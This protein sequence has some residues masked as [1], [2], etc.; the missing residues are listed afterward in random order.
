MKVRYS[1]HFAS[2]NTGEG[3]PWRPGVAARLPWLS[4]G[5]LLVSILGG[6]A[7]VG[8]LVASNGQPISKWKYQ[9]T[10]Y[11]SIAY[12]ITNIALQFAFTEGVTTAWWRKAL[13]PDTQLGDLHRS[14]AFGNSVWGAITSFRRFNVI[15]LACILI[16]MV[17]INGPLLQRAS[18]VVVASV[19][20]N[21]RL[22][23]SVATH[24]DI[25]TGYLS[26]RGYAVSMISENFR[27]IVQ[28]YYGRTEIAM[29]NTGCSSSGKCTAGMRGA[30]FAVNCSSYDV[31]FSV[32][33][34]GGSDPGSDPAIVNGTYAFMSSFGW[35]ASAPNNMSLNIQFK[36]TPDC[37]GR[38]TV[39]NCSL[40]SAIVQY[41][42]I[43]DG[44]KSTISLDP[45]STIFDDV[46]ESHTN[47]DP[48]LYGPRQ[49][50][51]VLGGLWFALNNRFA[52]T[53]HMRF[54]GAVG[55]EVLSTGSTASQFAVVADMLKANDAFNSGMCHLHFQD[56]TQQLLQEARQF[57]FRTAVAAAN[58]SDIQQVMSREIATRPVYQSHW[59]FLGI[60]LLVTAL[61]II[62]VTLTFHGF[63]HLGRRVTMS[64]IELAKAFDS[65]L[66]NCEDSNAVVG[67]LV[68]RIGERT[69]RYGI[70][71]DEVAQGGGAHMNGEGYS[72]V[73]NAFQLKI[74][75]V[76]CVSPPQKGSIFW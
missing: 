34:A 15:A 72:H 37:S 21:A 49:G 22:N 8:I 47:V 18:T 58:S 30:G 59:Q 74:A 42:V 4:L 40:S 71:S 10:V 14:W 45:S 7:S 57:M 64:P 65:P 31:P 56:P 1:K 54:I 39:R 61:A 35:S 16:A 19:V 48:N 13:K 11:L 44:N 24:L 27:P 76:G 5:A 9:P 3:N 20:S 51:T 33:P 38:L 68:E 50:P 41:P 52:S 2:T 67:T 26:G 32:L 69:V 55:Y 70:V 62:A 23:L 43:I 60:A 63:W 12:T 53:S 25:P 36:D 28:D 73:N 46:F 75:D 6:G 66:L 17:P 29:K